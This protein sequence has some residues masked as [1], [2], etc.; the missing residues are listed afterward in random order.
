MS[1]VLGI[2]CIL[3]SR[4]QILCAPSSFVMGMIRKKDRAF[5][6]ED[7]RLICDE[8]CLTASVATQRQNLQGGQGRSD[9]R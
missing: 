8:F 1:F 3:L 7:D 2:A 5:P 4:R 9:R 6:D